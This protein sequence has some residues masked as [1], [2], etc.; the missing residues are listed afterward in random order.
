MGNDP[1][2]SK[3]CAGV[4]LKN[5]ATAEFPRKTSRKVAIIWAKLRSFGVDIRVLDKKSKF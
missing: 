5:D 3:S 2:R 4:D 1:D